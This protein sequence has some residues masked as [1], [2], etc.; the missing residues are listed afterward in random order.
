MINKND[1][2]GKVAIVTGSS[3]G[4]GKE[5]A[6]QLACFGAK[7]VL[8]G[9]NETLLKAVQEE[10]QE[11]FNADC[12]YVVVDVSD[13]KQVAVLID[14]TLQK[15]GCID[16][17]VN[18]AGITSDTLLLRMSELDWDRVIDINLKGVFLCTKAVLKPMMKAR[19]GRIINVS[20]VVGLIG[21]PGQANYAASKSG[22]I[23]FTKSVAREVAS[24]QI[25]VNVVAPGYI[26][27]DM[28]N[29]LSDKVVEEACKSIP[30]SRLGEPKDIA[31]LIL[32]LTSEQSSYITGQVINVDGGLAM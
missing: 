2:E 30:Q 1:I 27:T 25:T 28:T 24:R 4:I 23:G 3:R 17:L 9:T 13:S 16:I 21:N 19:K 14:N 7:V 8:C 20:S 15:Y 31:N 10:L 12:F 5:V 11:Q 18:N 26:K 29:V 6:V 22:I 32:F